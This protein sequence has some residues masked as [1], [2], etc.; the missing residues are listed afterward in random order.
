[1]KEKILFIIPHLIGGGALK[2]VANLTHAMQDEYDTTVI[3][4]FKTDKSFDF[5]GKV[6]PLEKIPT[7]N[8]LKKIKDFIYIKR[9]VKKYKKENKLKYSISFL[10]RADF[11]NVLTKS[12]NG[13]KT[14]IS[15]RN[16]ESVEYKNNLLRK[17]QIKIA[18]KKCDKIVSISEEVKKDLIDNFKINSSKIV[19]I[20]NPC[21]ININNE[22]IDESL[23]IKGKT[24]I[25]MGGLKYQKGQWHLIRAFSNVIKEYSDARLLILGKGEYKDYLEELIQSYNIQN[26]VHL[27]GFVTNPY[28]Y[29]VKSDVFV[30]SSMFEGLGNSLMETLACGIP[31]ISTDYECGA[32]E[33]LA[34][35]TNFSD[36]VIDK[37]EYAKYGILVPVCDGKKYNSKDDLTKEELLMAEAIKEL[38][39]D[40]NKMEE[41]K[42][43]SLTRSK[44]FEITN[45]VQQWYKLF[46]EI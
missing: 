17:I 15:I 34:P 20:Y 10:V 7:K 40:N 26:N 27:V 42:Q 30:F 36:K 45:I 14:I 44:D 5:A 9:F 19:T 33:I 6:I 32:R 18:S 23:F 43:K 24:V 13:E 21:V 29:L 25:T 22:P 37:I 1:M 39:K 4:L 8:V 12:K 16:K 31:I 2:T 38:L 11:I 35:D 41:Y 3:A 28:D 46:Q